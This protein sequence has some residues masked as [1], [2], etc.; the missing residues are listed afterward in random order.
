MRAALKARGEE[1]SKKNTKSQVIE[2]TL[3]VLTL[4][5]LITNMH[6]HTWNNRTGEQKK[7]RGHQV[8]TISERENVGIMT[9]R[10]VEVLRGEEKKEGRV[11]SDTGMQTESMREIGI[12]VGRGAETE[13]S[14]GT[15]IMNEK[16]KGVLNRAVQVGIVVEIKDA[17]E[18]QIKMEREV[19]EE[20]ISVKVGKGRGLEKRKERYRS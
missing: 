4:S 20:K 5:R 7:A 13:R 14:V 19:R 15:E 3:V 1:E 9:E 16:R 10:E 8:D 18:A 12:Q 17:V 11:G 6:T 2:A